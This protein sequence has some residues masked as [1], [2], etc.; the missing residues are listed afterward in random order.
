[1]IFSSHWIKNRTQKWLYSTL[2]LF[3]ISSVIICV[4]KCDQGRSRIW[5]SQVCICYIWTDTEYRNNG[6]IIICMLNLTLIKKYFAETT[7]WKI[8][9]SSYFLLQIILIKL[10][11][12]PGP[13]SYC[14][15]KISQNSLITMFFYLATLH[16]TTIS[17]RIRET[18]NC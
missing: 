5:P 10:G 13:L 4:C 1:M 17:H 18:D 2:Y 15:M 7:G 16:M 3:V 14:K 12:I 9:P 8:I 6:Q 11:R